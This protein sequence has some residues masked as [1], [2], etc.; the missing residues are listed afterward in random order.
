MTIGPLDDRGQAFD[1]LIGDQR[2]AFD[3][4]ADVAYFN[5]ASLAPQLHAARVAGEAALE[6]RGRPWT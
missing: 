3:V 4:P 6:R 5:T 2:A 1:G